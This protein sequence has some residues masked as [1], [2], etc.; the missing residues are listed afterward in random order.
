MA[1]AERNSRTG[2]CSAVGQPSITQMRILLVEDDRDLAKLVAEGLERSSLLVDTLH[3]VSGARA[4]LSAMSFSA[5]VR[6]LGLPDEDGIV[7]L[8]DCAAG[9]TRSRYWF[10]RR[11]IG[12]KLE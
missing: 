7:L 12:S 1:A 8:H 9:A 6:D 11:E 5:I 10:L 2:A 3:S 4:A